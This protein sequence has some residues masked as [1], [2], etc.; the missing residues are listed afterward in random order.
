MPIIMYGPKLVKVGE[1][2]SCSCGWRGQYA[3]HEDRKDGVRR[4]YL[5]AHPESPVSAAPSIPGED[6]NA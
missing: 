5:T 2:A 6:A 1:V 3:D 4:H